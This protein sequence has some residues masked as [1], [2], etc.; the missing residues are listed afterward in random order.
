ML[1]EQASIDLGVRR[2]YKSHSI[3]AEDG[4]QGENQC[5]MYSFAMP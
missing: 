1:A 5:V 3:E 2:S 4:I